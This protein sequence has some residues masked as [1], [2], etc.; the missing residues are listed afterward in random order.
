MNKKTTRPTVEFLKRKAK[1]IRKTNGITYTT[2]LDMTA[3]D[4][5]FKNWMHYSK[6]TKLLQP[7]PKKSILKRPSSPTPSEVAIRDVIYGKV[8]G[9]RPNRSMSTKRHKKV[10]KILA[11]LLEET[12]YHKRAH[13]ILFQI[14]INLDRWLGEEYGPSAMGI[15]E[16]NSIYYGG[17]TEFVDDIPSVKK[18]AQLRALLRQAKQILLSAYHDCNSLKKLLEQFDNVLAKLD[19]WPKSI[20]VKGRPRR[21]IRSGTFVKIKATNE[22]VVVFNHDTRSN[23]I[24]GYS[25]A[26][27]FEAGRHEVSVSRS[28]PDLSK[29]RPLRLYLPYGVG[30]LDD[31]TEVL[32]NRDYSPL[33][34]RSLS[35]LVQEVD[36]ASDL[37]FTTTK[38]FYFDR[39]APYTKNGSANRQKCLD[40]LSEWGVNK[41]HH[42]IFDRFKEAAK[43]GR[44]GDII[45]I[46]FS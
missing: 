12:F 20:R 6:E 27:T 2:A 30:I 35:G 23:I 38:H 17:H 28:Q 22:L 25:D 7:L 29:Y 15:A 44:V 18:Q 37:V 1:L 3:L 42:K 14:R 43:S 45:S 40:I 10:G 4:H 5:G 11:E 33:W 8:L 26:G 31:G 13:T 16:F 32:F 36:P 21:Q 41:E 19:K 46:R 9:Q 34:A 24:V 39:D